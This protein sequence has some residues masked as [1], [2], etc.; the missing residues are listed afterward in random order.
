MVLNLEIDGNIVTF[1]NDQIKELLGIYNLNNNIYENKNKLK[2]ECITVIEK[3]DLIDEKKN[4]LISFNDKKIYNHIKFYYYIGITIKIKL[5]K[6]SNNKYRTYLYYKNKKIHRSHKNYEPFFNYKILKNLET[7]KKFSYLFCEESKLFNGDKIL[8]DFGNYKSDE[9]FDMKIN[10]NN[11]ISFGL[12]CF[13]NHHENK[14]DPD[15]R[16]ETTRLLR[17]FYYEPDVKFVV[18][19]WWTD[20]L[21]ENQHIF[22][23]KFNII[24][25]QYDKYNKTLKEYCVNEI[26][27]CTKNK[28]LSKIIYDSHQD[29]NIPS[30]SVKSINSMFNFK[31]N[32]EKEYL[33]DFI[34]IFNNKS[35]YFGSGDLIQ[36]DLIN[37]NLIGDDST[38]ESDDES[39]TINKSLNI[40]KYYNDNKLTFRGLSHYIIGLSNGD[41]LNSKEEKFRIKEWYTNLTESFISGLKI[42]YNDLMKIPF[43]DKIFGFN[44]K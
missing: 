33:N 10:I 29:I 3:S 5:E 40:D 26:Y 30:I 25:N 18:V 15:L 8:I 39:Y 7:N 12:E 19:F 23:I 2:Q 16:N 13:E 32:M 36:D 41:Y 11:D 35:D 27:K 4:N 20:L 17:K 38:N 24:L 21:E 22:D 31:K 14:N 43:E 1:G 34:N 37:S 42:A 44:T 6:D 28:K 9:R